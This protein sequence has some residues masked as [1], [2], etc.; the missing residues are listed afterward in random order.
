MFF[1]PHTTPSQEIAF[2][3]VPNIEYSFYYHT[4]IDIPKRNVYTALWKLLKVS[5]TLCDNEDFA[6]V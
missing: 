3:F 2:V 6:L 5:T 4:A 1:V